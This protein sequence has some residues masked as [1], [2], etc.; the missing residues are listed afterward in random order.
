[1]AILPSRK[2]TPPS[3]ISVSRHGRAGSC[4]AIVRFC[5]VGLELTTLDMALRAQ[6]CQ[7]RG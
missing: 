7:A 4:T 5:H 3:N 1:M 6:P 2:V